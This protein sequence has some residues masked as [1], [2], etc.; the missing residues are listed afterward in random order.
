MLAMRSRFTQA[1][2]LSIFSPSISHRHFTSPASPGKTH[3]LGDRGRTDNTTRAR[4]VGA[5]RVAGVVAP[6]QQVAFQ[7]GLEGRGGVAAPESVAVLA[8]LSDYLGRPLEVWRS[9]FRERNH[10][11]RTHGQDGIIFLPV[12]WKD[13]PVCGCHA[14]RDGQELR[15]HTALLYSTRPWH[16]AYTQPAGTSDFAVHMPLAQRSSIFCGHTQLCAAHPLSRR[17]THPP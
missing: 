9:H 6:R 5:G 10:T 3:A 4:G 15:R 7:G 1:G 8:N 11:T 2:W 14:P 16:S 12:S 13:K 17:G